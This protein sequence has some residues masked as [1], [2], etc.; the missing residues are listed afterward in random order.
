MN[1]TKRVLVAALGTVVLLGLTATSATASA[2]AAEADTPPPAS[3]IGL[4]L[5]SGQIHSGCAE[6][7]DRS[8]VLQK[9][10]LNL[11]TLGKYVHVPQF[12]DDVVDAEV[13]QACKLADVAGSTV[14][15]IL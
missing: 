4:P 12:G 7:H 15:P 14:P 10:I 9:N 6:I 1:N 5:P 13:N 2:I 11:L 3:L 8:Y